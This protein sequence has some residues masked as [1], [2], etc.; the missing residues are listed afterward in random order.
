MQESKSCAFTDLAIS[1]RT[2]IV[3]HTKAILSILLTKF[4]CALDGIKFAID[5]V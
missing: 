4:G 3:Y 5:Y 2:E 1:L